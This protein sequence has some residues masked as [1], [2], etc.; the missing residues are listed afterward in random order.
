[1]KKT[2]DEDLKIHPLAELFPVLAEDDLA[3]LAADIKAHGLLDPITLDSDGVLIDGRNRLLA[4]KIAGVKPRFERLPEGEEPVAV[5]ISKNLRRR[6]ISKGQQAMAIAMAYPE[7][8]K[9]GRGKNAASRKARET[10]GFSH[11]RLQQA[12]AILRH[13]EDMADAVMNGTL[14]F[15]DALELMHQQKVEA[16]LRAKQM[17]ELSRYPELAE[18]VKEDALTLAEAIT[19]M[20]F[21]DSQNERAKAGAMTVLEYF[22]QLPGQVTLLWGALR[23]GAENPITPELHAELHRAMEKLDEILGEAPK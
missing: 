1:M 14:R 12:R 22:E 5:I 10:A 15:D 9:G 6:H 20:R 16:E 3:D 21:R 18:Q 2:L 4:C 8:E 17:A 13:S 19:Q 7:P 23:A 11:D